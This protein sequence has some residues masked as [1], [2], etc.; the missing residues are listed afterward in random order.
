MEK[1][2]RALFSVGLL[3]LILGLISGFVWGSRDAARIFFCAS[4]VLA[5]A[6]T[7]GYLSRKNT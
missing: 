1:T 7:F 2:S 5:A 4:V 3:A 6:W